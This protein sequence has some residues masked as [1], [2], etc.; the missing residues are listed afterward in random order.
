MFPTYCRIKTTFLAC[1]TKIVNW[2]GWLELWTLKHTLLV[3]PVGWLTG[4]ATWLLRPCWL[5]DWQPLIRKSTKVLESSTFSQKRSSW[6]ESPWAL[7]RPKKK[8]FLIF[9]PRKWKM[10]V[11][12]LKNDTPKISAL[13][14]HKSAVATPLKFYIFDVTKYMAKYA[15]LAYIWARRMWSGYHFEV[16][17]CSYNGA[18]GPKMKFG[19]NFWP[20]GPIDLRPTRLN[21]I[22]QDLFRDIPLDH[23]WRTQTGVSNR[24]VL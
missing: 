6:L 23:I 21:C 8:H 16:L 20:E 14:T 1:K 19:C 15:F 22:L 5:P 24:M 18:I 9:P 10:D 17:H 2:K 3:L 4:W 11:T 7:G 12:W 13:K